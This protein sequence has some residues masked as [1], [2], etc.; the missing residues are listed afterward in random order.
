MVFETLSCGMCGCVFS[1]LSSPPWCHWKLLFGDLH[2]IPINQARIWGPAIHTGTSGE[3][4]PENSQRM[5]STGSPHC[6]LSL[7][8]GSPHL[9][10][11][12]DVAFTSFL[13]LGHRCRS[14]R[15]FESAGAHT[16]L[17]TCSLGLPACACPFRISPSGL[18]GKRMHL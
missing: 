14:G 12:L 15:L 11:S 5:P 18:R 6:I 4:V 16:A 17:T 1:F 7:E 2:H 9:P 13:S 3:L 10:T 8:P